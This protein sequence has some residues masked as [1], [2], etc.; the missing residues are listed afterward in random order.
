MKLKL[1][2]VIAAV[3]HVIPKD[4]ADGVIPQ[5]NK[6]T[7]VWSF[8]I[9]AILAGLILIVRPDPRPLIQMMPGWSKDA[10]HTGSRPLG[11]PPVWSPAPEGAFTSG[12]LWMALLGGLILGFVVTSVLRNAGMLGDTSP[13]G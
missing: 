13:D 9:A 6:K 4:A 5:G 8:V 1:L 11:A 12:H 2:S 3:L 10:F 7:F